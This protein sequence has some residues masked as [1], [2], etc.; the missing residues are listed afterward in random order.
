[1]DLSTTGMREEH[2][3]D[4]E[5]FFT[6]RSEPQEILGSLVAEP[7]DSDDQITRALVLVGARHVMEI[8]DQRREEEAETGG[9]VFLGLFSGMWSYPRR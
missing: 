5:P 8:R 9:E 3:P 6:A 1:M 4:L 7:L 2:L